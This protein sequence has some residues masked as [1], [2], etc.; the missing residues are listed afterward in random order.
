[1]RMEQVHTCDRVWKIVRF[2]GFEMGPPSTAQCSHIS[3]VNFVPYTPNRMVD[4]VSN[5]IVLYSDLSVTA[6]EFFTLLVDI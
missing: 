4:K 2:A 1:M 3:S 6:I 5:R